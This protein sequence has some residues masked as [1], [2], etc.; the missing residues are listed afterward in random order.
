M[1]SMTASMCASSSFTP[2]IT[3]IQ[4]TNRVSG[5]SR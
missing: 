4:A 1:A 5:N 2:G 3:G